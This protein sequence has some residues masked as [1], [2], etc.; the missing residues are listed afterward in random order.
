MWKFLNSG[1][2]NVSGVLTRPVID[3]GSLTE[4]RTRLAKSVKMP[5]EKLAILP[6]NENCARLIMT[7][8]GRSNFPV[9]DGK[10]CI[11]PHREKLEILN[12]R[13]ASAQVISKFLLSYQPF[14]MYLH[15][16]CMLHIPNHAYR[17][18]LSFCLSSLS[19][20]H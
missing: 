20:V 17:S 2:A 3:F 12:F 7:Y 18:I 14:E 11:N 5:G 8:L 16:L 4:K 1:R 6:A 10:K 9:T 19:F 15:D 13:R